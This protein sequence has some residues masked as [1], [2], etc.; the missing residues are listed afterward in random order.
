MSRGGIFLDGMR[1]GAMSVF[2]WLLLGT[3]V[4]LGALAHDLGF[5]LT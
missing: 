3:Y 4:G 5:S 2:L 1:A